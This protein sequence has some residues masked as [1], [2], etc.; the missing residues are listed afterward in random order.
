MS[1]Q[2]ETALFK[3]TRL[4]RF[5]GKAVVA[6]SSCVISAGVVW[7]ATGNG[8]VSLGNNASF[9]ETSSGSNNTSV[10]ENAAYTNTEEDNNTM[11]GYNAGYF[12]AASDN[13]FLGAN[14]GEANTS[15]QDNTY[16]GSQAGVVST[17]ADNNLFVG[18]QV[19]K[20]NTT[21]GDNTFI[22]NDAGIQNSTGYD[23]IFV[24][25]RA[26]Q[27]NTTG[28]QNIF[29]GWRAAG[30][31]TANSLKGIKNVAF[32]DYAGSDFTGTAS[33]NTAIGA[34]AGYD[35]GNGFGNTFVGSESGPH[36][37]Y[38]DWST[39]VGAY[40]GWDNNRYNKENAAN[41]NTAIGA[42]AG[43][44]NRD[45]Q[46]N[47]WLGAFTTTA[48][49]AFNYDAALETEAYSEKTHAAT[50]Y[51]AP[52]GVVSVYRTTVIG[53]FA[54]AKAN[55]SI[56]LGYAATTTNK[57]S[58]ALGSTADVTGNGAIAIGVESSS[59]HTQAVA[60]G[61]QAQ[62]HGNY[63]FS[64]GSAN[65]TAWD[66]GVN[67]ATTLGVAEDCAYD[68]VTKTWSCNTPYR[69]ADVVSNQVSAIAASGSAANLQLWADNG[70]DYDD[71]W[72]IQVADGGAFSFGSYA[73]SSFTQD[74]G[75]TLSR[76]ELL[77]LE[78]S[79]DIS[80]SGNLN[81]N[82]DRRL[83]SNIKPLNNA[84]TLIEKINGVT[85]LWKPE[86]KRN[87][88]KQYGVIAQDIESVIPDLVNEDS[89]GIKSVNYLG[90]VPVLIASGQVLQQQ[91]D[92]SSMVHNKQ[93]RLMDEQEKTLA[94]QQQQLAQLKQLLASNSVNHAALG[95]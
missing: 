68:T 2:F 22:G 36:T 89:H 69:F 14:A 45:G 71:R 50:N 31:S 86:L 85:Y 56:A 58:L 61:Y 6:V 66:S 39:F 48:S 28:S 12:N 15:G 23:N 53:A 3:P 93:K 25:E 76:S 41:R 65:T 24:G 38:A 27:N 52:G 49:D 9:S 37:E 54:G 92:D 70:N 72:D 79:G 62:S 80:L 43:Y 81:L 4:K 33:R 64:I 87:P 11:V 17:T 59:T 77:T 18:T 84:M 35:L 34:G 51:D 16:I 19:G 7:A 78:S 88:R 30:E 95:N 13:T 74:G 42:Y 26:G 83:K 47:V 29:I 82:S 75:E 44:S 32:G 94:K 55:D 73:A 40:S 20:V 8:S 1:Q 46:D 67:A 60:I 21:G 91:I 5:L 90:L 63:M 10:G 57:D